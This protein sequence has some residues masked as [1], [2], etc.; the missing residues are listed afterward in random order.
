MI[1]IVMRILAIKVGMCS[2]CLFSVRFGISKRFIKSV[3]RGCWLVLRASVVLAMPMS[4]GRSELSSNN[5][6]VD[7]QRLA[8]VPSPLQQLIF[9]LDAKK[10]AH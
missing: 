9:T 10:L 2:A 7:T 4:W 3:E 6:A 5:L 1:E 8:G